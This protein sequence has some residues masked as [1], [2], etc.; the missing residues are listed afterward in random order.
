MLNAR[1]FLYL[2]AVNSTDSPGPDWRQ[3]TPTE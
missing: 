3:L 1:R 2:S